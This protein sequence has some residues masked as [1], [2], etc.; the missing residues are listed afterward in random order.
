VSKR[1]EHNDYDDRCIYWYGDRHPGRNIRLFPGWRRNPYKPAPLIHRE[2][3]GGVVRLE[4]QRCPICNP[5]TEAEAEV[6]LDG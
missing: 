3:S 1:S 6:L 2:M 5:Y 4:H